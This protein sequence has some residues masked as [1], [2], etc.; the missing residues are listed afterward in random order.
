M[1]TLAL[2][3]LLEASQGAGARPTS[4]GVGAAELGEMLGSNCKVWDLSHTLEVWDSNGELFIW[5]WALL[6]Q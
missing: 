2:Q 1:V 5:P 6:S 3:C 4:M